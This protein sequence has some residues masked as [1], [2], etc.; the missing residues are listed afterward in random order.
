MLAVA[1]HTPTVQLRPMTT[2]L[3]PPHPL[4]ATARFHRGGT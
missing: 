3:E 4:A 1:G 2:I